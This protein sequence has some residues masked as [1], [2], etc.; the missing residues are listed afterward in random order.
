MEKAIY[1]GFRMKPVVPGNMIVVP[2]DMIVVLGNVFVVL[3]N[4]FVVLGNV[5][6]SNTNWV[7]NPRL[8]A[9]LSHF[10]IKYIFRS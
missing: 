10:G 3:G 4:V 1:A 9:I 2:G 8:N 5:V 7:P 6:G